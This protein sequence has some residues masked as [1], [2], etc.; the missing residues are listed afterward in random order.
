MATG[1]ISDS[2]R[3]F[4][5]PV[6]EALTRTHIAI[7]LTLFYGSGAAALVYGIVRLGLPILGAV[8]VFVAGAFFFTLIE[9]LVHRYFY[10]MS[11]D[12]PKR[13]RIQYVFHGIH[14]DHPRD[15][16]RL[17]LPPL[18]SVLLAVVFLSIF[19]ALLGEFGWAF[20]GGFMVGYAT[21]LLAHYAIHIH[22]PPKNFLNVIWKHHN[23][24]HFVGHEGAFG[25]SSPFWDYV[26][27]TMPPPP[28]ARRAAQENHI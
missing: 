12:S 25:V 6:L 27:G 11:A 23:I 15:K 1:S 22:R 21:Y 2:G 24:H 3:V 18:M 28:V 17:A 7:P 26:F 19:R 20:G 8:G 4:Q 5:N 10:H 9:Y 13:S 14:H 16:K